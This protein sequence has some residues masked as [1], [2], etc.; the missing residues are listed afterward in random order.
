MKNTMIEKMLNTMGYGVQVELHVLSEKTYNGIAQQEQGALYKSLNGLYY[1]RVSEDTNLFF[2]PEDVTDLILRPADKDWALI[3]IYEAVADN[4]HDANLIAYM[5]QGYQV[6]LNFYADDGTLGDK[7]LRKI[8]GRYKSTKN[9]RQY[10]IVNRWKVPFTFSTLSVEFSYVCTETKNILLNIRKDKK[11]II[12]QVDTWLT[13]NIFK[14]SKPE[15]ILI[16]FK[17]DDGVLESA[18]KLTNSLT[19][20]L[21]KIQKEEMSELRQFDKKLGTPQTKVRR[22]RVVDPVGVE[23][24]NVGD[25]VALGLYDEYGY[26]VALRLS[27]FK[28]FDLE[29]ENWESVWFESLDISWWH[30][31][32]E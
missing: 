25:L 23:G 16:E 31:G 5:N 6:T 8:S 2:R 28:V 4:F 3:Q 32:F 22:R 12:T 1:V 10:K 29:D 30:Q 18:K 27:D 11:Q 15:E 14:K 9:P 26:E 20:A 7:P 24:L 21:K 19:E 13:D 17:L